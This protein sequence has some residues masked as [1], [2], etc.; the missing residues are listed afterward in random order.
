M[1]ILSTIINYAGSSLPYLFPVVEELSKISDVVIYSTEE[2]EGYK[3]FV[4]DKEIGEYL[5]FEDRKFIIDNVDNYDYFVHS[6]DD[7]FIS[8]ETLTTMIELNERLSRIDVKNNVGLVR[9]EIHGGKKYYDDLHPEHS[10]HSGGNGVTD[11]I[12]EI[13]VIDDLICLSP[14]NHL[15]GNYILSRKQLKYLI[16]NGLYNTEPNIDYVYY[17]ESSS[18][19]MNLHMNK[20]IPYDYIEQLSVHHMSNKYR[21]YGL[22]TEDIDE[23]VKEWKSKQ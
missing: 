4:Y 20:I 18:S 17:L 9:Y 2:I 1:K 10:I 6:E 8:N 21:L 16:D 19:D 5:P 12:R 23:I 3:T 14:W 15:S 22:P 11:V 13:Q 7:I